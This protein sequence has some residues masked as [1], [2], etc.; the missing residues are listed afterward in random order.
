MTKFVVYVE[1]G[2][3]RR[4]AKDTKTVIRLGFQTFFRKAINKNVRVIACGPRD[5]ALKQ[6][7]HALR[8]K[9]SETPILLI[10]AEASLHST[11]KWQHLKIRDRWEQPVGATE[12]NCFLMVQAMEAW[13]IADRDALAAY[14]GNGL[15]ENAL[16]QNS[17]VEAIPKNQLERSLKRAARDTKKKGYHKIKDGSALLEQIDPQ[18]VRNASPHCDQLLRKL[19]E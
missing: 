4:D 15:R 9:P 11:S 17:N 19:S 2:G 16:P 10:D 18:L 1:G 14:F 8:T 6:F 13:F 3:N 7:R 12:D 5:E